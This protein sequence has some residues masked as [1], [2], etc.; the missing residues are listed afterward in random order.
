MRG[1]LKLAFVAAGVFLAGFATPC[2]TPQPPPVKPPAD[3]SG[4]PVEAVPVAEVAGRIITVGDIEEEISY[5]PPQYFSQYDDDKNKALFVNDHVKAV[6]YA[7]EAKKKGLLARDDIKKKIDS[8]VTGLLCRAFLS[9]A[10]DNVRISEEE[11]RTYYDANKMSFVLPSR[12]QV[13]QFQTK[14]EELASQIKAELDGGT[15]WDDVAKKH[16]EDKAN[17]LKCGETDAIQKGDVDVDYEKVVFAMSP[18]EVRGPVKTRAGWFVV[19]LESKRG[20]EFQSYDAAKG[21]IIST[22]VREKTKA[23]VDKL[24]A[25]LFSRY[26]VKVFEDK[27]HLIRVPPPGKAPAS[28]VKGG[29]GDSPA[30]KSAA[31][32]E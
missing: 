24:K 3:A 29:A 15:P 32:P 22:L 23:T 30:K 13:R 9:D 10:V 20:A 8:Y 16:V 28:P 4:R 2:Q 5:I 6:V 18:K 17:V 25:D 11:I 1:M 26:D 31:K 19:Q 21:G 27:I 7:E 12:V 14:T